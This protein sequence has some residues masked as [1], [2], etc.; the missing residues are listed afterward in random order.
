MA[1]R[2]GSTGS[3]S[4]IRIL[5]DSMDRDGTG[6]LD[7]SEIKQLAELLFCPDMQ[8]QLTDSEYAV[9]MHNMDTD[10]SGQVTFAEF[11]HW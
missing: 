2:A 3:R 4:A 7:I 5:F 1:S 9:M 11:S 6:D 8:R 10:G